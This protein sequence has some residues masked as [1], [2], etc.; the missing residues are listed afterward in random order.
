[1]AKPTQQQTAT[2]LTSMPMINSTQQQTNITQT[3]LISNT[4]KLT[5][6]KPATQW[7]P[8]RVTFASLPKQ[9]AKEMAATTEAPST[10]KQRAQ[11]VEEMIAGKKFPKKTDA[12]WPQASQK[13]LELWTQR[14]PAYKTYSTHYMASQRRILFLADFNPQDRFAQFENLCLQRCLAP[15]TAETYWTT[16]LGVQKAMS[17][18][19]CD[20]DPR[21][22]KLM[23][24]RAAAYPVQF[25]TPATLHDIETLVRTYRAQF[26]SLAAIVMM[27]FILGQRISDMIQLGTADLTIHKTVLQI[28]VRRG[29]TMGVSQPY[30]LWLRRS[31]YPTET[32][33][34]LQQDAKSKQRLFLLTELNSDEE[35]Q[36][37]LSTIRDMLTSVNEEL[38]LRSIRRGGLQ[39]MART[40]PTKIVLYHSRHSDEPMLMR[41]LGW[42]AAAMHRQ[43]EMIE[44]VDRT[45]DEMT[46]MELTTTTKL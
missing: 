24:A 41:Y 42:G 46:I 17:I 10:T 6:T 20:A 26:P 19:P 39:R 12:P 45:T 33:I 1:M 11:Q 36:A 44:A 25:P 22:T 32:L 37:V 21:T 4:T 15:T 2:V 3:N 8:R 43:Q 14:H 30:T 7:T 5:P 34:Q 40:S 31:T 38:E 29:K 13:M 16:W 35:R 9:A 27:S 18:T 23:K 28:T